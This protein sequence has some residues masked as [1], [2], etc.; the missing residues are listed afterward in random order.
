MTQGIDRAFAEKLLLTFDDPNTYGVH[1]L[2]N[3][4]WRY[5]PE[6]AKQKYL[7]DFLG[8]PES[9]DYLAERFYA[10]PLD[11]EELGRHAPGTLGK[12]FHHFIVDNGLEQNIALNYRALHE[13]MV[14]EGMLDA[15][16]EQF[17]YSIIRGFQSHDFLHVVTGY[18]A[19][20]GGELALQAY[21]LSQLR[22]PYFGMWM[23]VATTR[24]TLL[25]P[26]TI[27][28]TMD[29]IADGWQFGRRTRNIQLAKWEERLDE[30]LAD[31]RKEFGIDPAGLKPLGS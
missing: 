7:E 31:I 18:E 29:A 16:P 9:K 13:H 17:R 27:V 3:D 24:M 15:M 12:T 6:D 1:F 25:N 22:F 10:E 26:D 2:F 4:W 21:C 14:K 8:I 20:P 11:L 23:S 5:A 30:P 28:P 19:T